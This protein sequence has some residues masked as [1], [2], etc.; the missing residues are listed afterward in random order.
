MDAN[1]IILVNH[2]VLCYIYLQAY[3]D[4]RSDRRAIS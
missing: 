1:K 3:R 4:K 2:K